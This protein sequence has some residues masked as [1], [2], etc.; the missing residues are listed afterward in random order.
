MR[1][2]ISSHPCS[3]LLLSAFLRI[4]ILLDVKSC[5]TVGMCIFLVM[6]S[7]F[8]DA[9][10]PFVYLLWRTVYSDPLSIFN[11]LVFLLL[12]Y[13]QVFKW[14]H[15]HWR[16]NGR[17]LK[18]NPQID[19]LKMKK[20][21][22]WN[23]RY[24]GWD[25]QQSRHKKDAAVKKQPASAKD[26][27]DASSVPG[28][29]DLLEKEMTTHSSFLAWKIPWTEEPDRLLDWATDQLTHRHHREK[30]MALWT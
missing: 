5:L 6:V 28:L 15:E 16:K 3:C 24:I 23:D 20:Y 22:I 2:L 18:K 29:E 12:N 9:C 8:S 4:A 1:V 7:I 19:R 17:H 26:A 14:E 25:H 30:K 13:V 27:R 21:S 10:W 11:W